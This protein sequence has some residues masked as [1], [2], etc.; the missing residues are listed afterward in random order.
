LKAL[1]QEVPFDWFYL[2]IFPLLKY[3][4]AREVW[5][6]IIAVTAVVTVVPWLTWGRGARRNPSAE[7]TL[8]NCVGCELC[9]DDCPYQAIQMRK[10]TDGAPYELS[11]VVTANR[12]ASCG[13]CAGACDYNAINLPDMTE[14]DVK[15]NIRKASASTKAGSVKGVSAVVFLCAK[16]VNLDNDIEGGR[17]KGFDNAVAVTLPCIGMLQPSMLSIP[18]EE[19]IDGVFVSA[20]SHGDCRYRTGNTWFSR[21]LTGGRPPIVKKSIDRARVKAVY[22]SS[23][24]K[25]EFRQGLTAFLSSLTKREG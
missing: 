9:Q 3:L 18:F 10:R 19:G 5:A 13:I 14:A 8:E 2:F 16:S 17:I 23:V 22:L 6:A 1:T 21:R 15:E 11:A 7:V 4:S 12:C 25:A 24:E 20:C